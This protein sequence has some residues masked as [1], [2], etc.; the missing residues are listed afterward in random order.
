MRNL[1]RFSINLAIQFL[2]VSS[3]LLIAQEISIQ[4]PKPEKIKKVLTTHGDER[5]DY[6]YWMNERNNPKVID[7]LNAE[8]EYTEAAMKSTEKLQQKIYNEIKRRI[9]SEDNSIP[10]KKNGYYYYSKY[11]EGKEYPIYCR[12]KENMDSPEEVFLNENVYAKNFKI[13]RSS[14]FEISPDNKI[15]CFMA[16]TAGNR[17]YTLFFKNLETGELLEHKIP[18]TGGDVIWANDNKTIFFTLNDKTVRNYKVIKYVLGEPIE[19]KQTVL[20]EADVKFEFYIS[21]SRSGKYLYF[22]SFSTN[23]NEFKYLDANKPNDEFILIQPRT[24]NLLYDVQDNAEN[25]YIKTNNKANNFQIMITKISDPS[26]KNWKNFVSYNKEILTKNIIVF[27]DFVSTLEVIDGLMQIRIINL[28][29]KSEYYIIFSEETYYA[30]FGDNYDMH[31]D[32]LRYEFSSLIKPASIYQYN[33]KTKQ[34]TLLKQDKVLDNYNQED[35]ESKRIFATTKT[36]IKIPISLVYK[37]GLQLN[38]NN[39]LLLYAYGAYGNSRKDEFSYERIS[40]LDRGFV[41]AIAHVR[42]GA[43][44]GRQWYEE[45][46]LLNKL[47]TFT[48]FIDCAKYLIIENYTNPTKLCAIGKSAGGMLMAGVANMRPHLFKAIVAE[49]PW[50]DVLTDNLDPDLPLTTTEYE[51]WG[52]SNNI[53]D[54]NYIKK[55]SPYDNVKAQNYP[56]ILTTAA[57]NDTQVPYWSP[58]KWVAKLRDLKTNDN[59]VLLETNMYSG[60]AGASGRFEKY[61]LTA[62]EYAFMLNKVGINN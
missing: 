16:D 58:A 44:M 14:G 43:E 24:K 17:L 19:S 60:H 29:D 53:E 27:D 54:Y 25:F 6:Y 48:D 57:Y 10:Y 42:G 32:K 46:R 51:E 30:G 45:G 5:I 38:G 49:V 34:S 21:R 12:K 3:Q 9:S 28:I 4:P 23:S 2:L 62:L 61:F 56:S 39:P 52:N 37:K 11:E 1:I 18:N 31:S 41:F 36:G 35:Y 7:Y 47:N 50:T 59:P 55:Y 13:Y 40:L 22:E 26:I 20:E 33:M 15:L 8:N